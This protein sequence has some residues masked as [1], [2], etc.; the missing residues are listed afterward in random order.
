MSGRAGAAS[1]V[2]RFIAANAGASHA[3]ERRFGLAS[4]KPFWSEFERAAVALVRAQQPGATVLDVGGGRRCIY[5]AA[6]APGSGVR[7]VAVDV[8]AAELAANTD[9]DEVCVA[10]IARELP[11]AER[12]VELILSRTLLEHV[13]DVPAAVANMAR[14]LAPGGVTLNFLPGRY[15]LFGMAARLLPF[16]PLLRF[17]HWARPAT[18]GQIEFDVHYDRCHPAALERT[19]RAC[20]FRRVSVTPCWAQPGYFE[21]FVPLYLAHALYEWVVRRLDIRLLAAYMIVHAER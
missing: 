16:G 8:S 18:R 19:F 13:E 2:R 6:L 5:A 11:F 4:D 21:W 20:G 10:D 7:L 3:L 9:V 1:V 14:V 12:S 17:I 15:S